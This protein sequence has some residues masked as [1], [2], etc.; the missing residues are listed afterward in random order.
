M[1]VSLTLFLSIQGKIL[2]KFSIAF[3]KARFHHHIA[4]ESRA[5]AS[6]ETLY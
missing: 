6:I 2:P 4:A 3:A 5:I 1:L